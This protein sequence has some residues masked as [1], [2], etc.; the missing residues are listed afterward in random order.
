[1]CLVMKKER[2]VIM[3]TLDNLFEEYGEWVK[4]AIKKREVTIK[5]N[6]EKEIYVRGKGNSDVIKTE[7]RICDVI[8]I[9]R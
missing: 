2:R 1:M 7:K 8:T 5:R 3:D 9:M 4:E 6:V